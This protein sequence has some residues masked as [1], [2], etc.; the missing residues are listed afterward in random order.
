M[1]ARLPIALTI[2]T[3]LALPAAG[4]ATAATT[5]TATAAPAKPNLM[6]TA[7][8]GAPAALQEGAGFTVKETTTNRGTRRTTR[9]TTRFYLTKNAPA[10]LRTRKR[11]RSNPR[12][13]PDDIL[14]TGARDVPTLKPGRASTP[15]KPTS[16]QVPIGTPAGRYAL[17][18]CADDRGTVTER[19]EDDNCRAAPKAVRVATL[20]A[21]TSTISALSD[22]LDPPTIEQDTQALA[23]T[24]STACSIV[25][26]T[27][28]MT[29]AQAVTS[30]RAA[31][32]AQAG[33]PAMAAF[34]ASPE[35]K[36]AA[37]AQAAAVAAVTA[38]NPGAA[39]IAL[40]RASELQP[41]RAANLRNAATLASA[42]GQP[43]QALALLDGAARLDDGRLAPMG[44]PAPAA[45][46][47]I[48]GE[49]LSLL[50]RW[51]EAKAAFAA[52]LRGSP[53][54][55][56]AR[57][58]IATADLCKG[59]PKVPAASTVAMLR[60]GRTRRTPVPP[61][62]AT[63]GKAQE[64]RNVVLPALPVNAAAMVDYAK[65]DNAK[66]SGEVT[67]NVEKIKE[68]DARVRASAATISRAE[69]RA[70]DAILVRVYKASSEP[71]LAAQQQVLDLIGKAD[72]V[73]HAFWAPGQTDSRYG[74]M[75]DEASD[76]C[77]G[78]PN[79]S[80][81]R[82]QHL[83]DKCRPALRGAHAEW[84]DHMSQAYRTAQAFQRAYSSRMSGYAAHIADPDV[85]AKV[86]AEIEQSEIALYSNFE[87]QV[88]GWTHYADMYREE[89]VEPVETAPVGELPSAGPA[90]GDPCVPALKKVNVVIDLK[91][92]KIKV[93]CEKITLSGKL[94]SGLPWLSAF[95][96]VSY[97]PR[98]GKIT[99]FAGSKGELSGYGV[100][101][102]FKSGVY[103][104]VDRQGISD[105]GWRVGPS[106]SF[107][108]G[109]VEISALK[110]QCDISFIGASNP[111]F[112]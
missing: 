82:L 53:L 97:N 76:E 110:E 93:N 92:V 79:F 45:T 17:L 41:T 107:G 22:V 32:Q 3:A 14:L 18:A 27:K 71:D 109:P 68:I 15:R 4:L 60:D 80:E 74:V 12:A 70:R 94:D 47:A 99:V 16:V 2:T 101:G 78:A 81:C 50:G 52:A 88:L 83:N 37:K 87:G 19:R 105:L 84:L 108:G 104:E 49:A 34:K 48:R 54:L 6:I 85:H 86:M 10:S 102:D 28:P 30:L 11:S 65:A 8:T 9:S 7:T 72:D 56:E 100:K 75:A 36:D 40:L 26:P 106:I 29:T 25:F 62:D 103:L 38:G 111:T 57:S 59:D 91:I 23:Q 61:V 77:E 35:Y 64:L 98:A 24:G 31:V 46:Q 44:I 90:Q 33:A 20:A 21:D 69:D 13:N 112:E 89:C 55:S 96:E 42:I 58:G 63:H 51:D 43:N 95:G 1:S 73:Q 5:A 66:V 39:L 67:A